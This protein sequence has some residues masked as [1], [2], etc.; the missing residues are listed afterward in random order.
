MKYMEKAN[1]MAAMLCR[2][3]GVPRGA[4]LCAVYQELRSYTMR[5]VLTMVH[6]PH[7]P[8]GQARCPKMRSAGWQNARK[9]AV[10]FCYTVAA[11]GTCS[12]PRSELARRG[13]TVGDRRGLK[14]S[15]PLP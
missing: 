11:A 9:K 2:F 14:P 7:G 15:Y 13:L 1:V 8:L 6:P 10:G 4:A 12:V 3:V 5:V